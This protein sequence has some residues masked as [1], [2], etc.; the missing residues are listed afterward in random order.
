MAPVVLNVAE[1]P[2]VAKELAR[3]LNGGRPP[4]SKQGKAMYNRIYTF[5]CDGGPMLGG[6]VNMKMTSVAGHMMEFAFESPY[7]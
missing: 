6:V 7:E 2:S 1:K 3:V 5:S 4:S